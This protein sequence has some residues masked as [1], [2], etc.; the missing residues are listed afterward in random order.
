MSS[1]DSTPYL[2]HTDTLADGTQ[3]HAAQNLTNEHVDLLRKCLKQRR[4]TL[5]LAMVETDANTGLI[6]EAKAIDHLVL[7]LYHQRHPNG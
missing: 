4:T 7:S 2:E 1:R 3:L 6:E 5:T